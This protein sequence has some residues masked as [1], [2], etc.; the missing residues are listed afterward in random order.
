MVE[1]AT[2]VLSGLAKDQETASFM[3]NIVLRLDQRSKTKGLIKKLLNEDA[4]E[5]FRPPSS[6]LDHDDF[7][8]N[9]SELNITTEPSDSPKGTIRAPIYHK[10]L[11]TESDVPPSELLLGAQQR[12]VPD[13]LTL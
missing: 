4:A 1:K 7:G 3:D 13:Q 9:L 12:T 6:L 8:D 10:D 11:K 2:A 5:K